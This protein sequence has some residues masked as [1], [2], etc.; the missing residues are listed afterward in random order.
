MSKSREDAANHFGWIGYFFGIDGPASSA[1]TQKQLGWRP[2][3]PGLIADL[4][5][6]HY[7]SEAGV[8]TATR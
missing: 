8:S 5:M 1:Q 2:T 7:F 4:E 3:Q 6:S